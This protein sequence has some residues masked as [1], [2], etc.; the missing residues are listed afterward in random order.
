MI[1]YRLSK[2]IV[3]SKK[4]LPIVLSFMAKYLTN[5]NHHMSFESSCGDENKYELEILA[6]RTQLK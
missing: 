1:I 6:K 2:A 3:N 4:Y 5:H